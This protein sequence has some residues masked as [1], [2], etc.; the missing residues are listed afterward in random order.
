VYALPDGAR[1][2]TEIPETTAVFTTERDGDVIRITARDAG[3]WSMLLVGVRSAVSVE[4][5]TVVDH[6]QGLLVEASG[7]LVT[8][9]GTS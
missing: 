8:V 3:T 2:T 7:G 5:G 9:R 6:D 1:V 4:G